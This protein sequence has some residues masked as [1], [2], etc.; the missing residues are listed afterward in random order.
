MPGRRLASFRLG[1]RAEL[2][3]QQLLSPFAF[4][5][6]VPRQEDIGV[7][8]FCSLITRDG[9]HLKSGQLFTVQAKSSA[10]P[11]VFRDPH[12]SA[13]IM[14]LET[15]HLVCVA[16]RDTLSMD[17]YSTWNVMCGQLAAGLH[18]VTL[19]FGDDPPN[20]PGVVHNPDG[21]Q[22]IFL[23]RPIV[24]FR[25]DDLFNEG[26]V[27]QAS[28]TLR[29]WLSFDRMNIANRHAGVYWVEGPLSYETGHT[30]FASG[31]SGIAF[32]WHQDNLPKSAG[33]L[34]RVAT[35]IFLIFRDHLQGAE[36]DARRAAL[37]EVLRTHWQLLD[38]RIKSAMVAQG[39]GI[40]G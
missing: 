5:V 3:V 32:Y 24:R 2:L 36:H 18:P 11:L 26:S 13:W 9:P 19:R 34:G 4:T 10:A 17:I 14:G 30:P 1:D 12:E 39:L 6:P 37:R 15:P 40:E 22:E 33:N 28:A 25:T 7:D 38:S 23:G 16:N 21:S 20:F 35:A 8:F 31:Q 27:E 29:E